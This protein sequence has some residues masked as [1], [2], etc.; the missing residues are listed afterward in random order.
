MSE[1]NRYLIQDDNQMTQSHLIKGAKTV[2]IRGKIQ[3]QFKT[4]KNRKEPNCYL[5][6]I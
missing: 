5:S 1:K 4:S 3:N 2:E 6:I